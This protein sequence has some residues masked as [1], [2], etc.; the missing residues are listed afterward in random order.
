MLRE[1]WSNL[2]LTLFHTLGDGCP[3]VALVYPESHPRLRRR[4]GAHVVDPPLLAVVGGQGGHGVDHVAPVLPQP[5]QGV[6]VATVSEGDGHVLG[7]VTSF[8][9]VLSRICYNS[10]SLFMNY[11]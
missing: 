2:L 6:L 11:L 4:D 9:G 8:L 3:D 1:S 7:G 5:L 10:F